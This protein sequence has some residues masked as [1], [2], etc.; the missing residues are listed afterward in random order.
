M[1]TS[2]LGVVRTLVTAL[3][4]ATRPGSAGLGERLAALPRLVRAT[5]TGEYAGASKGRLAL[6]FGAAVYLLS[7]LNFVTAAMLPLLG[8][9]DDAVVVSWIAAT[10]VTETEAFLRWEREN[11]G[12]RSI[13]TS[14]PSPPSPGSTSR[15]SH[16][17]VIPARLRR[18]TPS[19]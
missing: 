15:S 16:G 17:N 2:R 3:R 18:A 12:R 4:I 13:P 1:A 19:R 7:P 14:P 6:M 11:L 10:V 8:L 5:F 9:A